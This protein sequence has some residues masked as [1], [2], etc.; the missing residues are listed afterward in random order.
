VSNTTNLPDLAV[1]AKENMTV[2]LGAGYCF[3]NGYMYENTAALD[4]THDIAHTTYDRID[5]VVIRFD[6]NPSE[7][8]V[9]AYIKKGTP[10]SSPVAPSLTRDDYVYELSVA[11]VLIIAGKS[12]IEQYQ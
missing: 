3:A 4:L 11:R 10:A 6:H 12:Y 7:R 5:R 9:Y 8:K 2:T 1:E